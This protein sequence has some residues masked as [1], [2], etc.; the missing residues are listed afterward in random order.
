[1]HLAFVQPPGNTA[2][3][4]AIYPGIV[5][6]FIDD[7][8]GLQLMPGSG[9]TWTEPSIACRLGANPG[10]ATL[11]G[12][13]RSQVN[14]YPRFG[15][16]SLDQI[17]TGYTLV[18]SA[19]G[20]ADLVSPPFDVRAPAWRR[21]GPDGA[22]VVGLVIDPAAPTTVYAAAGSTVY[23]SSDGGTA[24]R[25]LAAPGGGMLAIDPAS[26][27]L[28]LVYAS[29]VY[30]S[31]DGGATFTETADSPLK[32]GIYSIA[33]DASQSP[34]AV[35]VGTDSGRGP[36]VYVSIDQ[37]ASWNGAAGNGFPGALV[38]QL[39]VDGGGVLYAI[40]DIYTS[41]ASSL[42]QS[43]DGGADWSQIN[44]QGAY[45]TALAVDARTSGHIFTSVDNTVL[46][47][48]DGGA[49]FATGT[50]GTSGRIVSL[51]LDPSSASTLFA[52][53]SVPGVSSLYRSTDGGASFTGVGAAFGNGPVKAV[54]VN[55]ADSTRVYSGTGIGVFRSTSGG[56]SWSAASAGMTGIDVHSLAPSPTVQGTYF[57]ATSV[58]VF[59]TNDGGATWSSWTTAGG[60]PGVAEDCSEVGVNPASGIVYVVTSAH[61]CR[62]SS[63]G[64][65]HWSSMS[66][67]PGGNVL[68]FDP[69]S[70]QRLYAAGFNSPLYSTDGGTTWLSA[71]GGGSEDY[72]AMAVDPHTPGSVLAGG[73]WKGLFHS[74][75][76]GM[77]FTPVPAIAG[78]VVSI[79][80]DPVNAGVV[81]LGG[82]L[83]GQSDTGDLLRSTDGGATWASTSPPDSVMAV[84]I[85]PSHP[86]TVY[87][88][89]HVFKSSDGAATWS[90]AGTGMSQQAIET[91]AV[92]PF[93]ATTLYAGTRHGA[94]RSDTGGQ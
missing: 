89:G 88:G 52:L 51:V 40:A 35:Y 13:T 45:A 69:T 94:Y 80:F 18:F 42:Y 46:H 91:I 73:L 1:M 5:V 62:V 21:I 85:D 29:H 41:G 36:P 26:G 76:G 56:T 48:T 84:A 11:S 12:T 33:I 53:P 17:G 30:R 65:A 2:V 31:S 58:G 67:F 68:A 43:S 28:Y 93:V 38:N 15:D 47:S 10:G 71:T 61:A 66:A 87:V 37:G 22:S 77:S 92:D 49:T 23:K 81:Y 86:A 64:G 27:V 7:S 83:A 57:A 70:G 39:A 16:L 78:G 59:E 63:D 24:W 8:T 25:D 4:E 74:S 44:L 3:G 20:V 34:S 60:Q 55:P 50:A 79:T 75:D 90:Y 72:L 32:W 14:A 82:S 6:A 9:G 19:Q 54:A